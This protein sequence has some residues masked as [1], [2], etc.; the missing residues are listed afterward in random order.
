MIDP[1]NWL[2]APLARLA[3][4]SIYF[5]LILIAAGEPIDIFI[6]LNRRTAQL[7]PQVNHSS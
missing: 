5:P 4:P 7:D 3:L 2:A 6:V 1:L